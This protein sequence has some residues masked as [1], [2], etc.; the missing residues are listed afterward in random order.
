MAKSYPG[1][2]KWPGVIL[3]KRGGQDL[4]LYRHLARSCP[5]EESWPGIELRKRV[6]QDLN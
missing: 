4:S 2:K 6:G 1:K 3:M 5:E